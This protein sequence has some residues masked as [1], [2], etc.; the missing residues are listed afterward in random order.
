[1]QDLAHTK[2]AFHPLN[3]SV[4]QPVGYKVGVRARGILAFPGLYSFT[5][6]AR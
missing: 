1:M 5:Y 6:S 4:Q 3:H 2:Y